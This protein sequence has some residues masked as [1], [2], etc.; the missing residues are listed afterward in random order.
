MYP[1][2]QSE[3]T[4]V[5]PPGSSLLFSLGVAQLCFIVAFVK[6]VKEMRYGVAVSDS[7]LTLPG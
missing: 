1:E 7:E 2:T 3:C 5:D 4:D 6:I